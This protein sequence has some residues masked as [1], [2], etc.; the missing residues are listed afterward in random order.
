MLKCVECDGVAEYIYKGSSYC[1][2][3]LAFVASDGK[4]AEATYYSL[5]K[6]YIGREKTL[7]YFW[8]R[9]STKFT[10]FN[11]ASKNRFLRRVNQVTKDY[12]LSSDVIDNVLNIA[13]NKNNYNIG[14]II[15]MMQ[16]NQAQINKKTALA[17]RH[18]DVYEQVA[19]SMKNN[20]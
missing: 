3:H 14:F 8:G 13:I 15:K 4:V 7:I 18:D 5:L 11:Y 2:T 1:S 12:K 20:A 9:I 10:D 16:N 6:D 19:K 17:N